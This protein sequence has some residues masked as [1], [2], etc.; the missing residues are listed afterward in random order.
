QTLENKQDCPAY[1]QDLNGQYLLNMVAKEAGPNRKG[2]V[3]L[4]RWNPDKLI[5]S[6]RKFT[7]GPTLFA[8]A[9]HPVL[10]S[11][12]NVPRLEKIVRTVHERF[13]QDFQTLLGAPGVGAATIRSLSLL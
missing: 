5:Q 8:P 4:V 10:P 7:E 9:A 1:Q 13:P 12:I 3:D 6:L 2:S 11:E